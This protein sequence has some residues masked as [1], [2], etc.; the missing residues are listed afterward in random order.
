MGGIIMDK[1]SLHEWREAVKEGNQKLVKEGLVKFKFGNLSSIDKLRNLVAIKPSGV[2]YSDLQDEDIVVVDLSGKQIYGE[3]NPSS[4]TLTHL[5]LY[6]NFKDIG[7]IIHTHSEFATAF[8][9]A[10]MPIKCLG[11]THADYFKGDIL[12]TRDL[13]RQEI[14]KDY[15]MNTGKVIVE[16][17]LKNNIN[18]LEVPACLVRSHGPFVWGKDIDEAIENALLLEEIAKMNFI[19]NSL[20]NHS[21]GAESHLIEKHY[22]RKHGKGAYYGQKK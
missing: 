19:S 4:D 15:E 10:I 20:N 13:A 6:K 21:T 18:P 1:Y 3:K 16:T 2:N 12:V 5:E 7:A 9:Q 14:E 22:Y 8:A 17:F 11:T